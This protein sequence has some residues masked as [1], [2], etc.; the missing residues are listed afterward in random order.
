M[1]EK[2]GG[3]I[4]IKKIDISEIKDL[5]LG[6]NEECFV[7]A[8]NKKEEDSY[9]GVYM[10]PADKLSE[11]ISLLFDAGVTYQEKTGIDIGF[12]IGEMGDECSEQ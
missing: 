7:M 1:I 2:H 5:S 12:G 6:F 9:E 10:I 3:M 11:I 8:V 4:N